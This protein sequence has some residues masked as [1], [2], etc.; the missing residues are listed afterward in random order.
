MMNFI[1]R[2][3]IVFA[4]VVTGYAYKTSQR[5]FQAKFKHIDG[6]PKGAPV[7][8][9]GVRIGEVV[10]TK[11]ASDGV[12]VK[13]R[14]TNRD[15]PIPPPGS[16][17]SITSF[18]PGRGRHLEIILPPDEEDTSKAW[19][20]N[21]PVNTETWLQASIEILDGL[22]A[23]SNATIQYVTPEN[24]GKVRKGFQ[25]ASGTFRSVAD[26]LEGYERNLA[27]LQ[28]RLELKTD[29]AKALVN[30]LQSSVVSLNEVIEDEEFTNSI[31]ENTSSFASDI[32]KVSKA[33]KD[34]K[35][36]GDIGELKTEVV[37]SLNN[38]NNYIARA[39]TSV[40]NPGLKKKMKDFNNHIESLNE[41]YE[42]VNKSNIEEVAKKT[43]KD[44]RN[45]ITE[46][47]ETTQEI[48][49]NVDK[50][51]KENSTK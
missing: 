25:E 43:A 22:K 4:L 21:E 37:D 20:V 28:E 15:V 8:T 30:I 6:L 49:L 46:L 26:G 39:D 34:P 42:E 33:I 17:L 36:V 41:F 18:I 31:S 32:K 47:S 16:R 45:I 12:L 44:A 29:Q 9:L 2:L 5:T 27:D 1:T 14:I 50:V 19:L 7:T 51:E 11:P 38:I 24:L 10:S 35:L 3:L 23:Y 48:A 40:N 13:I